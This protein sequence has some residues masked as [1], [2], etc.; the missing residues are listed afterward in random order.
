MSNKTSFT[1]KDLENLSGIKAH[2]I[3]IWEK[4]HK[5]FNP[6]RTTTNIRHYDLTDLKKILNISLLH[7]LDYKI[8]FINNLTDEQI[9]N[10]V[11]DSASEIV[12]KQHKVDELMLAAITFNSDV[13]DDTFREMAEIYSFREIFLEVFLKL[14]EY[15]GISWQSSKITPSHEH[16]ISNCIRQKVFSEIEKLPTAANTK[17]DEVLVLFLPENEIHEL[18]L[19][20][21]HYEYLSR[22]YRSVFLGQS[23]PLESLL[24]LQSVYSK[25]TFITKITIQPT[26]EKLEGYLTEF[27]ELLLKENKN[28][29]WV[30]GPVVTGKE[31]LLSNENVILFNEIEKML[32]KKPAL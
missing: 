21:L 31:E 8:S 30:T 18:S 6:E 9:N 15:I 17:S 28:Q 32:N 20:Y 25:I 22:G 5:I 26:A 24:S 10:I 7:K 27:E 14:L 23:T 16:F 4:R 19:L 29:L 11:S 12:Q 3:R 1:I 2:T 13:F